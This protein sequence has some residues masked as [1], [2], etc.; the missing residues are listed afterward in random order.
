MLN[1]ALGCIN[2]PVGAL[3]A[4]QEIHTTSA[5]SL[6]VSETLTALLLWHVET[7]SVWTHVIVHR[8]QFA[9]PRTTE[10]SALA[11]LVSLA[12]PIPEDATLVRILH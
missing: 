12:I 2:P 1:A 9:M 8:M 4:S 6:S 10:A 3:R 11:F 5:S 7:R